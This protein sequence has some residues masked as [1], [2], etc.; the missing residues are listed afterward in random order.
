MRNLDLLQYGQ[1]FGLNQMKDGALLYSFAPGHGR[2]YAGM[3]PEGKHVM[4]FGVAEAEVHGYKHTP[5]DE[6]IFPVFGIEIPSP[7]MAEAISKGFM[8]AAKIMR[9]HNEADRR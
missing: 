7:R 8:E 9:Q 5:I 1:H 6:P 2:L 3:N 4:V